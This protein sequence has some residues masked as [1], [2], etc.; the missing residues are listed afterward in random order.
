M[1]YICLQHFQYE[2]QHWE[3]F[4]CS[5][6]KLGKTDLQYFLN[7]PSYYEKFFY[8]LVSSSATSAMESSAFHVPVLSFRSSVLGDRQHI[9]VNCHRY[10]Q[11]SSYFESIT[12]SEIERIPTAVPLS[13]VNKP[14]GT[15]KTPSTLCRR[16]SHANPSHISVLNV[17]YRW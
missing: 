14:H 13:F 16:F 4:F 11:A 6:V 17:S 8:F 3:T 15:R 10:G 7:R 2:K 5:P 9:Y 12:V 1:K